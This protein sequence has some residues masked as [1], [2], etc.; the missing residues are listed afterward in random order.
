MRVLIISSYPRV[1]RLRYKQKIL[2]GL[3][4]RGCDVK[5]L[6]SGIRAVEYMQEA[7]R[8][9]LLSLSGLLSHGR[10]ESAGG[11]EPTAGS[12]PIPLSKLADEHDV[13]V[14]YFRSLDA[15]AVE[16]FVVP[17]R[18]EHGINLSG[19]FIPSTLLGALDG[20]IVGGH[21]G[22]LPRFRGRD[23]VRWP[24]LLNHPTVVTHMYLA[25][26]YDMGDILLKSPVKV[27]P[28]DHLPSVRRACQAASA[29]GHLAV[30]DASIAGQLRPRPQQEDEGSTFY[31][32]GAFLRDRVD[33][34]LQSGGYASRPGG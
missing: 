11:P 20:R 31:E 7:R 10:S 22:D 34:V 3:L 8:R 5:I 12:E 17:F 30:V 24:I 4:R 27:T 14:G 33:E 29:E 28:G 32:M 15:H 6:Y 25:K 23:T 18:P 26:E 16:T 13:E 19:S 9:R 21:Y 1:D 2:R